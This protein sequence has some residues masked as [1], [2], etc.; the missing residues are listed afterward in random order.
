MTG[1][2]M[3]ALLAVIPAAMAY[4]WQSTLDWWLLGIAITVVIVVFAWWRGTFATTVVRRRL[5]LLRSHDEP[6]HLVAHTDTDAHTTVVLTVQSG[7][8]VP[9]PTLASYLDRYGVRCEAVRV[10]RRDTVAG[11]T[12]WVGLTLS[13]AANLAALQARSQDL[14]LRKTAEV[15]LRRLADHLRELGYQ[16]S[17]VDVDVPELAGPDAKERWRAVEDGAKGYVT[18]YSVPADGGLDQTLDELRTTVG[19]EVWTAV[20]LTGVPT[21][22]DIT[23]VCAVRSE[24][25]PAAA[26]LPNLQPLRGRQRST[27][28]A[29]HPESTRLLAVST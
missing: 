17:T 8:E 10:T 11:T 25:P 23:A 1:R 20:E 2:L 16:V 7:S 15:T 18:C 13:A 19:T 28:T 6:R 24:E 4:P 22:P 12:T 26:P 9:L 21:R 14:P 3:L 29:L 27:L 5:A